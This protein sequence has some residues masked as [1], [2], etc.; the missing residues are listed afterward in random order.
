MPAL[1]RCHPASRQELP[2]VR[3]HVVEIFA[4]LDSGSRRRPGTADDTTV[5]QT[6]ERS[7]ASGKGSHAL[8]V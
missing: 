3:E 1:R 8:P 6:R 5:S 7:T 4:D 2:L